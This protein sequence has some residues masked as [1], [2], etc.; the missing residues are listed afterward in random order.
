MVESGS[1]VG[2]GFADGDYSAAGAS[3]CSQASEIWGTSDLLLKVKEPLPTEYG[4]LRRDMVLFTY[5]HLAVWPDLTEALQRAGTT[6]VAYE[7]VE[8]DDGS[9]PL[10]APMSEIAGRLAAHAIAH[11]L[12]APFGGPG[13]LIGG[14]PGVAPARVLVIGGGVAG[15][16]AARI[17][18]GMGADVTILER[19][20]A[21]V[22]VLDTSLGGRVRVLMS[23]PDTLERELK[24][25]DAIIGSILIPGKQAMHV[26]RRDHLSLM[27]AGSV[28]VDIAIDQGGCVATSSATT[29][30]SPTFVVDDVV[31]YCVANMPA[32]VPITATR[33]LTNA[34]LP[35]V[36]ELAERLSDAPAKD[37][38]LARGVCVAGGEIVHPALRSRTQAD[39]PV[40]V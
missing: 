1:G 24:D 18:A 38:R 8:D 27:K 23:D 11:H 31:H 16:H 19:S 32:A 29:H 25:V 33:S 15:S 3:I 39:G 20:P 14:A 37:A 40:A 4:Y 9:L 6:A 5:L 22:R 12:Q 28:I 13:T 17:A 2:S 21:R 7:T 34:T 26:L 36:Q 35:F 10:L 30:E